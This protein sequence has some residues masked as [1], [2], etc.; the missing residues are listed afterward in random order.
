M[1]HVPDF[2]DECTV[3]LF[4]EFDKEKL[5]FTTKVMKDLLG[6]KVESVSDTERVCFQLAERRPVHLQSTVI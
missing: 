4:K 6:H 2:V 3:Q 1:P 5:I